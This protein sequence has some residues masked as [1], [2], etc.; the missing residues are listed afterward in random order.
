MALEA[1]GFL[2]QDVDP[3]GTILVDT[4]NGFN[5]L[6]RLAMIWTVRHCCPSGA[7]LELN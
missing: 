4:H 3:G 6:I 1:T 2:T 7:R 5:K